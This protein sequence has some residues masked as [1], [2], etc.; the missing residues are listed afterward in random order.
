MKRRGTTLQDYYLV[1]IR[2][3]KVS[4]FVNFEIILSLFCFIL[5][6]LTNKDCKT[7]SSMINLWID[8]GTCQ[9]Q[10]ILLSARPR[11]NYNCLELSKENALRNM[12]LS[13]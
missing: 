13:H 5:E 4:P 2:H 6:P 12:M 11:F 3:E 7:W 10:R 8:S 1:D 9:K